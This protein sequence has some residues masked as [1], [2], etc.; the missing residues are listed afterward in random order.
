MIAAVAGETCA[1][2]PTNRI[3]SIQRG[4]TAV[5]RFYVMEHP[6]RALRCTTS[7]QVMRPNMRPNTTS[8]SRVPPEPVSGLAT[9]RAA[10]RARTGSG[11]TACGRA[12]FRVMKR[13]R[14]RTPGPACNLRCSR[15]PLRGSAGWLVRAASAPGFPLDCAG[16][17]ARAPRWRQFKSGTMTRQES[18]TMLAYT[19]F[20]TWF[21]SSIYPCFKGSR[22][23]FRQTLA[24]LNERGND[25][26]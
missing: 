23:I 21:D 22:A 12:P 2:P 25:S 8:R 14:P 16:R 7:R 15:L 19:P 3:R 18:R 5:D 13:V 11:K 4:H 17:H 10:S 9:H 26:L 20:V 1:T 6:L 24:R